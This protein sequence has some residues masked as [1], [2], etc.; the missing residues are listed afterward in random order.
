M[1]P[2]VIP[3]R[4]PFSRIEWIPIKKGYSDIAICTS[5]LMTAGGGAPVP[6]VRLATFLPLL[7]GPLKQPCTSGPCSI[8]SGGN[9]SRPA[10]N[11]ARPIMC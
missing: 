1:R 6:R 5:G 7:T 2:R 8:I 4:E 3:S 10:E 11:I 9:H